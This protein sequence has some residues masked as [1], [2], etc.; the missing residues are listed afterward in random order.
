MAKKVRRNPRQDQEK[1]QQKQHEPPLAAFETL[2]MPEGPRTAICYRTT[3]ELSYE[4]DDMLGQVS[5]YDLAKYLR[6]NNYR[7]AVI[8]GR[9]YWILYETSEQ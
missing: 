8:N 3:A 7:T 6:D 2:Y 5:L 9:A 4:L 1:K